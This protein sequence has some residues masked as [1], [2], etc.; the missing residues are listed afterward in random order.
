MMK[1]KRQYIVTLND[2]Y[3]VQSLGKTVHPETDNIYYETYMAKSSGEAKAMFLFNGAIGC[4]FTDIKCRL[5][6]NVDL[7]QK[8][9]F[10]V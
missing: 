5:S 10:S 4:A 8:P 1:E 9:R 6:K 3:D 7:T 2:W